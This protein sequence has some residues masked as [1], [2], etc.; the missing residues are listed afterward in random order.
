MEVVVVDGGGGSWRRQP[1]EM[2]GRVISGG[3]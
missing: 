1:T 3:E 2:M